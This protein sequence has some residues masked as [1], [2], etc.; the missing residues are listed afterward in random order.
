[1]VVTV[2]EWVVSSLILVRLTWLFHIVV[3]PGLSHL[4][5]ITRV[6]SPGLSHVVVSL[7]FSHLGLSHPNCLTLTWVVSCD[8]T[9]TRDVKRVRYCCAVVMHCQETI[10]KY[11]PRDRLLQVRG[12]ELTDAVVF[13]RLWRSYALSCRRLQSPWIY[14]VSCRRPGGVRSSRWISDLCSPSPHTACSCVVDLPHNHSRGVRCAGSAA[15]RRRW[16][17]EEPSTLPRTE[18]AGRR[19][20][21]ARWPRRRRDPD[22]SRRGARTVSSDDAVSASW[23]SRDIG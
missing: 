17:V 6:V 2:S 1:M 20:V 15:G 22:C 3:T 21:T 16:T 23:R 18:R 8:C 10:T 19:S 5:S 12:W 13:P 9:G 11:S 14:L 7:K 4:G